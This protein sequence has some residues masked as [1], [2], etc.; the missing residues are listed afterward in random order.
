MQA[1]PEPEEESGMGGDA[2]KEMLMK[3][4]GKM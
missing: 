2:E 4:L 3:L 1:A